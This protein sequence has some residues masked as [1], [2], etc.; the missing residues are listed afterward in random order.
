M[1]IPLRDAHAKKNVPTVTKSRQVRAITPVAA[2]RWGSAALRREQLNDKDIG[3]IL[4]EAETGQRPEWKDI[5]N[6]S[7]TYKSY[8]AQWK[9][10]AVMN[11]IQVRHWEFA[12]GQYKIA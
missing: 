4:E 11:G 5:A 2:T 9:S 6:R 7:P 8:W 10:L 3:P 1:P 12:D